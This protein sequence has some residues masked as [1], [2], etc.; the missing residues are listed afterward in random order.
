MN[1]CSSERGI[2]MG[3]LNLFDLMVILIER[4]VFDIEFNEEKISSVDS[5]WILDE[6]FKN[7]V[8]ESNTF[9][10]SMIYIKYITKNS[11]EN[12]LIIFLE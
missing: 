2:L 3:N 5:D 6:I 9:T 10:E 4:E 7:K 11:K 12:E 1:K 8:V